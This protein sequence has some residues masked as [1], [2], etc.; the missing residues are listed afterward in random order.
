MR[1][2][3]GVV[4]PTYMAEKMQRGN[5]RTKWR[6]LTNE[7]LVEIKRGFGGGKT[8]KQVA[9]KLGV[10]ESTVRRVFWEILWG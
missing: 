6:K 8:A 4:M 9:Q 1:K 7:Q 2:M 3:S 10:G 5:P